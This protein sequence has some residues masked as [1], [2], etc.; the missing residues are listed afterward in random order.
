[1]S[2][3]YEPD[4][5]EIVKL[6]APAGRWPASTRGAVVDRYP[7]GYIVEIADH[8]GRTLELLELSADRLARFPLTTSLSADTAL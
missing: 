5:H 4:L 7:G 3:A 6:A 2:R 1:M 8:D